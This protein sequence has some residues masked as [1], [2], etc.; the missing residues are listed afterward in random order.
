M[1][2]FEFMTPRL[3]NDYNVEVFSYLLTHYESAGG[4]SCQ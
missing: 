1:G 3:I 4:D 2:G